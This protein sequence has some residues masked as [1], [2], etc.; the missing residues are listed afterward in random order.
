MLKKNITKN[1]NIKM[2]NSLQSCSYSSS[3][4]RKEKRFKIGLK[5]FYNEYT[6]LEKYLVCPGITKKTLFRRS[7][8]KVPLREDDPTL[9]DTKNAQ[10]PNLEGEKNTMPNYLLDVS[11]NYKNFLENFEALPHGAKIKFLKTLKLFTIS[12]QK[13]LGLPSYFIENASIS[14]KSTIEDDV[15][16]ENILLHIQKNA[17]KTELQLYNSYA[18]E[19][20]LLDFDYFL[21]ETEHDNNLSYGLDAVFNN[22]EY[23]VT[24][25]YNLKHRPDVPLWEDFGQEA[26]EESGTPFV[27]DYIDRMFEHALRKNM[28]KSIFNDI[29]TKDLYLARKYNIFSKLKLETLLN[30]FNSYEKIPLTLSQVSASKL[31]NNYA[32]FFDKLIYTLLHTKHHFNKNLEHLTQNTLNHAEN[33]FSI[34]NN[35][36]MFSNYVL[37]WDK[38]LYNISYYGDSFIKESTLGTSANSYN[39]FYLPKNLWDIFT[40]VELFIDKL[41]YVSFLRNKDNSDAITEFEDGY[42]KKPL[43]FIAN[44]VYSYIQ[45]TEPNTPFSKMILVFRNNHFITAISPSKYLSKIQSENVLVRE[46]ERITVRAAEYYSKYLYTNTNSRLIY[47]MRNTVKYFKKTATDSRL[48]HINI[49]NDNFDFYS[50][51]Y[52]VPERINW[53]YTLGLGNKITNIYEKIFYFFAMDFFDWFTIKEV[54]WWGFGYTLPILFFLVFQ[55][56]M[57]FIDL[58]NPKRRKLYYHLI[59]YDLRW[60]PYTGYS[61]FASTIDGTIFFFIIY[62]LYLK[63][64]IMNSQYAES[65]NFSSITR[66]MFAGQPNSIERSIYDIDIDGGSQYR[67]NRNYD[68]K[69][70][71]Y[72]DKILIKFKK[73]IN[74]KVVVNGNLKNDLA[75]RVVDLNVVKS[76]FK[77]NKNTF[78]LIN[79]KHH[80]T[81][82]CKVTDFYQKDFRVSGSLGF[83]T[84]L[85][86]ILQGEFFIWQI[87]FKSFFAILYRIF[88]KPRSFTSFK[89][90]LDLANHYIFELK[91][92][93]YNTFFFITLPFRILFILDYLLTYYINTLIY[94]YNVNKWALLDHIIMIYYRDYAMIVWHIQNTLSMYLVSVVSY[95]LYMWYIFFNH[96]LISF[97]K[98]TFFEIIFIIQTILFQWVEVVTYF[99]LRFF[100]FLKNSF[101]TFIKLINEIYYSVTDFYNSGKLYF[102]YFDPIRIFFKDI[103]QVLNINSKKKL[104]KIDIFKFDDFKNID[105]NFYKNEFDSSDL[106]KSLSYRLFNKYIK[107]KKR[108]LKINYLE[109]EISLEDLRKRKQLS[110]LKL[111]KRNVLI[112]YL[113]DHGKYNIVIDKHELISKY[114]ER[115]EFLLNL[116]NKA[117]KERTM[118]FRGDMKRYSRQSRF[119]FVRHIKDRYNT[120]VPSRMFKFK[121]IKDSYWYRAKW[122]LKR[123][124]RH[125]VFKMQEH[126]DTLYDKFIKYVNVYSKKFK[127]ETN[128]IMQDSMAKI[129]KVLTELAKPRLSVVEKNWLRNKAW[130]DA[131]ERRYIGDIEGYAA[132]LLKAKRY[133]YAERWKRHWHIGYFNREFLR[134]LG[135]YHGAKRLDF[136]HLFNKNMRFR[137]NKKTS[138]FELY[139]SKSVNDVETHYIKIKKGKHFYVPIRFANPNKLILIEKFE[140]GYTYDFYDIHRQSYYDKTLKRLFLD[141][142]YLDFN[143]FKIKNSSKTINYGIKNNSNVFVDDATFHEQYLNEHNNINLNKKTLPYSNDSNAN[144]YDT[145]YREIAPHDILKTIYFKKDQK[146]ALLWFIQNNIWQQENEL[147]YSFFFNNS[148][149]NIDSP[150]LLGFNKAFTIKE[151]ASKKYFNAFN[152]VNDIQRLVNFEIYIK[153]L[154]NRISINHEYLQIII[155]KQVNTM[156]TKNNI[157]F[158]SYYNK[159]FINIKEQFSRIINLKQNENKINVLKEIFIKND[160]LKYITSI[161]KFSK[162]VK[163]VSK[164]RFIIRDLFHEDYINNLQSIYLINVMWV[165]FFEKVKKSKFN[166]INDENVVRYFKNLIKNTE[167]TRWFWSYDGYKLPQYSKLISHIN[168]LNHFYNIS[169]FKNIKLK[170]IILNDILMLE[171]LRFENGDIDLNMKKKLIS[172]CNFNLWEDT[173]QKNNYKLSTSINTQNFENLYFDLLK[174]DSRLLKLSLYRLNNSLY[175]N[176]NSIKKNTLINIWLQSF[177]SNMT[178]KNFNIHRYIRYHV[179]AIRHKILPQYISFEY[180]MDSTLILIKKFLAKIYI[181]DANNSI[182]FFYTDFS[183]KTFFKSFNISIA[184]QNVKF[185]YF[186]YSLYLETS[187]SKSECDN[188]QY[189][190]VFKYYYLEAIHQIKLFLNFIL[191]YILENLISV[192]LYVKIRIL[193]AIEYFNLLF[194]NFFKE[195]ADIVFQILMPFFLLRDYLIYLTISTIQKIIFNAYLNYLTFLQKYYEFALKVIYEFE[196]KFI[197]VSTTSFKE[198]SKDIFDDLPQ[199]DLT[200]EENAPNFNF[201]AKEVLKLNKE[202]NTSFILSLKSK[203]KKVH[204]VAE[205]PIS[206]EEEIFQNMKLLKVFRRNINLEKHYQQ[207][208][209]LSALQK[210]VNAKKVIKEKKDILE[211]SFVFPTIKDLKFITF[212]IF[213]DYYFEFTIPNIFYT[214]QHRWLIAYDYLWDWIAYL[215]SK[216]FFLKF[217]VYIFYTS[218]NTYEYFATYSYK[219]TLNKVITAIYDIKPKIIF[220]LKYF[221]YYW[222]D[223]GW[224]WRNLSFEFV[225]DFLIYRIFLIDSLHW[226]HKYFSITPTPIVSEDDWVFSKV[227]YE[228]I[229]KLLNEN[230]AFLQNCVYIWYDYYNYWNISQL[231]RFD[232]EEMTF[233]GLIREFK[234]DFLTAYWEYLDYTF[235]L[236]HQD[237]FQKYLNKSLSEDEILIAFKLRIK[238]SILFFLQF[239][240]DAINFIYTSIINFGYSIINFVQLIFNTS[241]RWHESSD[242]IQTHFDI[243]YIKF[244]IDFNE[245][246]ETYKT[247]FLIYIDYDYLYSLY[248]EYIKTK[249]LSLFEWYLDILNK[250][251]NHNFNANNIYNNINI[252]LL[253]ENKFNSFIDYIKINEVSIPLFFNAFINIKNFLKICNEI[254]IISFNAIKQILIN[255]YYEINIRIWNYLEKMVN[256]Y[257]L[258][259]ENEYLYKKSYLYN[260]IKLNKEDYTYPD[261]SFMTIHIYVL[262][263]ILLIYKIIMRI[264]NFIYICIAWPLEYIFNLIMFFAPIISQIFFYIVYIKNS[265]YIYCKYFF[266]VGISLVFNFLCDVGVIFYEFSICALGEIACFLAEVLSFISIRVFLFDKILNCFYI[267]VL[268]MASFFEN[269]YIVIKTIFTFDLDIFFITCHMYFNKLWSIVSY[270]DW[271]YRSYTLSSIFNYLQPLRHWLKYNFRN[272]KKVEI[273]ISG[274][275]GRSLPL[276]FTTD[277][278]LINTKQRI[279]TLEYFR[280]KEIN[281]VFSYQTRSLW[282]S[283]YYINKYVEM[284][285]K[286][287]L[288]DVVKQSYFKLYVMKIYS[289]AVYAFIESY[290]EGKPP[291][292]SIEQ[293]EDFFKLLIKQIDTKGAFKIKDLSRLFK[294]TNLITK[295]NYII[296]LTTPERSFF[297]PDFSDSEQDSVVVDHNYLVWAHNNIA[298]EMYIDTGMDAYEEFREAAT[299]L[300]E[301][302]SKEFEIDDVSNYNL[303]KTHYWKYP[304]LGDSLFLEKDPELKDMLRADTFQYSDHSYEDTMLHFSYLLKSALDV[305]DFMVFNQK[306]Y[307]FYLDMFGPEF[308]KIYYHFPGQ[309]VYLVN[310]KL[311]LEENIRFVLDIVSTNP[312]VLSPYSLVNRLHDTDFS[313]HYRGLE[314][315]TFY[316]DYFLTGWHLENSNSFPFHEKYNLGF[317]SMLDETGNII[318]RTHKRLYKDVQEHLLSTIFDWNQPRDEPYENLEN[319]SNVTRTRYGVSY[320]QLHRNNLTRWSQITSLKIRFNIDFRVPWELPHD[321]EPKFWNY[322]Y[323]HTWQ[324]HFNGGGRFLLSLGYNLNLTEDPDVLKLYY[325]TLNDFKDWSL[326]YYQTPSIYLEGQYLGFWDYGVLMFRK[327]L[328]FKTIANRCSSYWSKLNFDDLLWLNSFY[329]SFTNVT[330]MPYSIDRTHI[331]LEFAKFLYKLSEN[332]FTPPELFPEDEYIPLR[333]LFKHRTYRKN[334]TM[335]SY[336]ESIDKVFPWENNWSMY[337]DLLKIFHHVP[338][339][340]IEEQD[341]ILSKYLKK[342]AKREDTPRKYLIARE[343]NLELRMAYAHYVQNFLVPKLWQ[344]LQRRVNSTMGGIRPSA[345]SSNFG[346]W[347]MIVDSFLQEIETKYGAET[348]NYMQEKILGKVPQYALK[349]GLGYSYKQTMEAFFFNKNR[350]FPRRVTDEKYL[351]EY[352]YAPDINKAAIFR[353]GPIDNVMDVNSFNNVVEVFTHLTHHRPYSILAPYINVEEYLKLINIRMNMRPHCYKYWV[354]YDD[355][356]IATKFFNVTNFDA[357]R[358]LQITLQ[359]PASPIMEGIIDLHHDLFFFILL[360]STSILIVIM[361]LVYW[362]FSKRWVRFIEFTHYFWKSNLP[363]IFKVLNVLT[364]FSFSSKIQKLVSTFYKNSLVEWYYTEY[365]KKRLSLFSLAYFKLNNI[366]PKDLL[367]LFIVKFKVRQEIVD[368][369]SNMVLLRKMQIQVIKNTNMDP[370][371]DVSNVKYTPSYT[372]LEGFWNLIGYEGTPADH[373]K[374][375]QFTIASKKESIWFPS[376]FSHHTTIEVVWTIIPALILVLIALPSFSLLFSMD[377]IWQ[378]SFTIKVIGNQWYWSYEYC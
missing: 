204:V 111:E 217:M 97:V 169:D 120:I 100:S 123:R 57:R 319:F 72:F 184:I 340:F 77:K 250:N 25:T 370:I 321:P 88:L 336:E 89:D 22:A 30:S 376:L 329:D 40:Q 131:V 372:M 170:K 251:Y 174:N 190:F 11:E 286:M 61:I 16:L 51:T 294:Q 362:S 177:Y 37:L 311:T 367:N 228:N 118:E 42:Q 149:L 366:I 54:I 49:K 64:R 13:D 205:H 254:L 156:S 125:S 2:F 104:N 252:L 86:Y 114:N 145:N 338:E 295:R 98:A 124:S 344:T 291:K 3:V 78:L 377:Q 225:Y 160:F 218:K 305:Y 92:S 223:Q 214:I 350:F 10:Q 233:A 289:Q 232:F 363:I 331:V 309:S 283:S 162:N 153:D 52:I 129:K 236:Y 6:F 12:K 191:E 368:F 138:K 110:D 212:Y 203:D 256:M 105:L 90:F 43:E 63:D 161:S 231:Y 183:F 277:V 163:H 260:L 15:K 213:K 356:D 180:I 296:S 95:F 297:D 226:K 241:D 65:R 116:Y 276:V 39:K 302:Y 44:K 121:F 257:S 369:V 258:D 347:T 33:N 270:T 165:S 109:Q 285:N 315:M 146:K 53:E 355:L 375:E 134:F 59:T 269:V 275:F 60:Y 93:N 94:Y 293:I 21:L 69:N 253:K 246:Y 96:I 292:Y 318:N 164:E 265:I 67:T 261:L 278:R 216:D 354:F 239:C 176:I 349:R 210:I 221:L 371:N 106:Q 306:I 19:S 326:T 36:S 115:K 7:L 132:R 220:H 79:T 1:I 242:D 130:E 264:V 48:C 352:D 373:E 173:L 143:N 243:Y 300:L 126:V 32:L 155:D 284:L 157:V 268:T 322:I 332:A 71:G 113:R 245:V 68:G 137:F 141:D 159:M 133:Y 127:Y 208:Y 307:N 82:R 27:H 287:D 151:G 230:N 34:E 62:F 196:L 186:K 148:E 103:L 200:R 135:R 337:A 140:K 185:L 215:S 282:Y 24:T 219:P 328:E 101:K 346:E 374:K 73:Y 29:T 280:K 70:I 193:N 17:I 179:G 128:K 87:Y 255:Y 202:I 166:F 192:F 172:I 206:K 378:P 18:A 308:A 152:Y 266:N 14:R 359:D 23:Q 99:H 357:P 171:K 335:D 345:M 107:I 181:Y 358:D 312:K 194:F 272:G 26:L 45:S 310:D 267:F 271:W 339:K 85:Q 81:I 117:V 235:K 334:F 247:Q 361:N 167:F 281:K 108:G 299:E 227:M 50:N 262:K 317:D 365:L 351:S 330:L 4:Y 28:S 112:Q 91:S 207:R 273:F 197:G 360:I 31:F 189:Y 175:L 279:L 198:K 341:L 288:P 76:N 144:V 5:N 139:L 41:V 244:L 158:T 75:R 274:D 304:L 303:N 201:Y 314:N 55:F 249:I 324:E 58:E 313:I 47:W 38:F 187:N 8:S 224:T 188:I 222:I 327:N 248:V 46:R 122:I 102:Y 325:K 84:N 259:I 364:A 9:H 56:T 342:W 333:W 83:F 263:S 229:T 35:N 209:T 343:I 182:I 211:G 353:T 154:I 301:I 199:R 80:G 142:K 234:N 348:F 20:L 290:K 298:E 178:L 195:I 119:H 320:E 136:R 240:L 237:I 147:I 150:S 168:I 238:Y 74:F 316:N 323:S 66:R